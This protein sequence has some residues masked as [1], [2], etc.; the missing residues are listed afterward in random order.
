MRLSLKHNT[1]ISLV[2]D[3]IL[4]AVF[5]LFAADIVFSFELKWAFTL[6]FVSLFLIFL[7][8]PRTAPTRV[9]D[10]FAVMLARPAAFFLSKLENLV[11]PVENLLVKA[12][13]KFRKT[14]PL[15]KKSIKTF[16]E[17]QKQMADEELKA[18]LKQA[19]S[20]LEFN[21]SKAKHFMI[22][23]KKARFVDAAEEVGPVLLSELHGTNR[24]IFPVRENSETIGTVR[25]DS[26]TMLKSGGKASEAMDPQM[27]V[28]N[29]NDPA[30]E[31]IKR[32]IESA[33][34][35]IFAENETGEVEG[36]VYLQDVLDS[37]I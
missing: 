3:V 34:E 36:I 28:V 25:L 16:L 24:K 20:G 2:S 29:K 19:I 18:D 23:I 21:N 6:L 8:L 1:F 17:E 7:I 37:L 5:A 35:M 33:P 26:L 10:K 22:N 13:S 4:V 15:D 12:E 30:K 27:V 31:I 11:V 32:F 9:E 14:E